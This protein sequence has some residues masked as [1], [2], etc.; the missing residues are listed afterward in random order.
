MNF[1]C[2]HRAE[3]KLVT[4]MLMELMTICNLKCNKSQPRHLKA[5]NGPMLPPKIYEIE[6]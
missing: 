3:E 1:L 2:V 5:K 6:P 4:I